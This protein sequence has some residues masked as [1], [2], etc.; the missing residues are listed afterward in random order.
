MSAIIRPRN[1]WRIEYDND[2][3][4][5]DESFWEWWSV[6]DGGKSY[7]CDDEAEAK[8]LC[9]LLNASTSDSAINQ[10]NRATK[11][12][13]KPPTLRICL[14]AAYTIEL[15]LT[16]SQWMVGV[17]WLAMRNWTDD[18][19]M[20][21]VNFFIGPFRFGVEQHTATQKP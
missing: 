3:G 20:V 5:S 13:P 11:L 9:G 1:E 6:T 12:L 10:D 16:L 18:G 19:N 4:Q 17:N 14:T 8:W 7:K 15:T 2:T 21:L